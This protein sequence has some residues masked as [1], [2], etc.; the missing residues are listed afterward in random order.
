MS[1]E[2]SGVAPEGPD[3][4]AP[5]RP[6]LVVDVSALP[7]Q[8]PGSGPVVLW[9]DSSQLQTNIVALA[10]GVEIAAH[11]ETAVDVT[12]TVLV[13]SLT[14]R[15]GLEDTEADVVVVQAPAVV[16]LPTGTRRSLSAGPEGVTY[17]TAHRRRT[18][19]LPTVR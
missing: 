11:V 19:L 17:L 18:G 16:V 9:S 5:G 7:A 13:G 4:E 12:L 10:A 8:Q 6:V 2:P 3:Q 14:L 15:H 1:T